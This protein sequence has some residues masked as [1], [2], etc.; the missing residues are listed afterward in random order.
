ML[1]RASVETDDFMRR[2]V[3]AALLQAVETDGSLEKPGVDV[4]PYRLLRIL[5]EGGMG[6]VWLAE[7]ADGTLQRQ[8]ALKL[9]RFGWALGVEQRLQQE[10]DTLAALEHP[11]IAR[12]YDAGVAANGR[13]YL[14]MELVEGLPIDVYAQRHALSV[15]QRLRLFLQVAQATAFA[16][17]RLIVHRDL[18]PSNIL[19]SDDGNVHLL[20]FGAAKLLRDETSSALTRQS[21]SAFS[22]DYASPEQIRRETVTVATDVYS[23]GIVLYELLTG[24]RPYR[25]R[26]E[27]AAALEEAIARADVPPASSRVAGDTRLART[28]RGDLDSILAKALQRDAAARYSSVEAFAEDVTRHLAG[29]PVLAQ[30]QGRVY[31][32]T[33]FVRRHAVAVVAAGA[34]TLAIGI[35][36]GL[37][38]WQARVARDEAARA[39]RAKNFVASILSQ[40]VPR[41]GVGGV[42]TAAD[43]LTVAGDRIE[44][45]LGSDP[46]VA[47][48]LGVLVADSFDALGEELKG[49]P[50]LRAAVPR[51]ERALGRTHP[52]TLRAKIGLAYVLGQHDLIAA[53]RV[54]DDVLPDVLKVIPDNA[55]LA[56]GALEQQS[57]VLAKLNFSEQSYAALRQAI[58]ISTRYL[59]P[60]SEA[61]IAE[62]GLLSNTYGRFGARQQQLETATEAMTRAQQA[63]AAQ[64]PH[65]TLIRIERWYADALRENDRPGDAVPILRRVLADQL[66]L[67]A[68]VTPRVRNAKLQLANALLRVGRVAEGLPLTREVVAL[69]LQQNPGESD[70]R[71]AFADA[72]AGALALANLTDEALR[73]DDRVATIAARLGFE[74]PRAT[75]GRL[76]RRA[77][78]LAQT[79]SLEAAAAAVAEAR[80]LASHEERELQVQVQLTDAMNARLQGDTARALAIVQPLADDPSLARQRF[81]LQAGVAA[82]LA[83]ILLDRGDFA[84]AAVQASRCRER[85]RA[86]QI[87]PSV[88]L[89]ICLVADARSALHAGRAGEAVAVLQPLERA[90]RAIN[91][92]SPWHGEALYWLARG[93]RAQGNDTE[94]DALLQRAAAMLR[95]STLPALRRLRGLEPA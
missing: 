29:E 94:A 27:S 62:I 16:H 51:A 15:A 45:E 9:P 40:A 7:R 48:E 92:D 49:E 60:L 31:L 72:L 93:L 70:D 43:L 25:L 84:A 14:A 44:R 83:T 13:P 26:R 91:P 37:A 22:P 2:P 54:L 64:R 78:L 67:D 5:G 81:A 28:L 23:L 3:S 32:L 46:A 8:V 69:E 4:G 52:V 63:F 53:R 55:A 30:R 56:A 95:K 85:A 57:F 1:A 58:D 90:W 80:R 19:V 71:R 88:R 61:A 33:K 74:P 10:R 87:E 11:H 42:V 38:L 35:G 20:D 79:G 73:E 65:V 77:R 75:I 89:A 17:A 68:A 39:E 12:L 6:T 36:G 41:N 66:R 24:Q 82:E 34:V 59:G 76:L 21:G 50:M 47:A 86:A 18:K